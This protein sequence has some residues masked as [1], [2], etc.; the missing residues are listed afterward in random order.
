MS[1]VSLSDKKV[2]VILPSNKFQ[3]EEYLDSRLILSKAFASVD[4]AS[5]QNIAKGINGT[6]V[7]PQYLLEDV[8]ADEF[9]AILLIGG[10]GSIEH[11][12]NAKLIKLLIKANQLGKL[13]CAICLAPVTLANSGLLKDIKA[14]A[15]KSAGTYLRS[16]GA[17]YTGKPVEISGNLITARGP[18][19]SKEFAWAIVDSLTDQ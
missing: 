7:I 1:S 3:D 11:W 12:H 19:A 14:T 2:L 10:V 6:V 9:D 8:E 5:S 16:K 18:E 13:I 17:I 15:Y 4:V